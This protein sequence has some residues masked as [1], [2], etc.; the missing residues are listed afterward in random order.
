M[1]VLKLEKILIEIQSIICETDNEKF[2]NIIK[3]WKIK[4]GKYIDRLPND[5]W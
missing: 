3:F 2:A 1:K 4:E 5:T